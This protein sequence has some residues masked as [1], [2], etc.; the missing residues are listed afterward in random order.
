MTSLYNFTDKTFHFSPSITD[1]SFCGKILP[2]NMN[3]N[4]IT[5]VS[6]TALSKIKKF[7]NKSL[8]VFLMEN[9]IDD[10]VIIKS[11]DPYRYLDNIINSFDKLKESG[12]YLLL[13]IL[14]IG[15]SNNILINFLVN[16]CGIDIDVVSE[17]MNNITAN[18]N[19]EVKNMKAAL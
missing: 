8:S 7:I 9:M 14:F 1:L 12:Y 16:K 2:L 10:F 3:K 5:D 13:N 15:N 4:L 19:L 11:E 17:F 6:S 18:Q